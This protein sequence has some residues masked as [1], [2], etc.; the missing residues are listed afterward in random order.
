MD[1]KEALKILKDYSIW[2]IYE[3]AGTTKIEK[4]Q[5]DEINKAVKILEGKDLCKQD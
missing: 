5:I 2:Y 1:K 4:E 3:T